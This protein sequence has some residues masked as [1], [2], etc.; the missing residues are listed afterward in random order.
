MLSPRG[1]QAAIVR[2]Y[3]AFLFFFFPVCSVF[4]FPY[5]WS[6]GLLFYHRWIWDQS[7]TC[8][9]LWVCAI[10]TKR[11]HHKGKKTKLSPNLHNQEIEPRLCGFEFWCSNH[12][13][14]SPVGIAGSREKSMTTWS[15]IERH[16]R[17]EELIVWL[18]F[19]WRK[20]CD[21]GMCIWY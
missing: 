7:F 14:M 20:D 12:W 10:H 4:V 1:K 17:N 8:A 19:I 2:C 5:Q 13:A 18:Y 11:G 15:R 9:Q 6:W 16:V 21:S 3:V